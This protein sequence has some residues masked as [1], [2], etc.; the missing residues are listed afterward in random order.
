MSNEIMKG[1][2]P[3]GAMFSH[4]SPPA[5]RQGFLR[6]QFEAEAPLAQLIFDVTVG[7]I[8]PIVCLVFDPVV[9]RGG[10]GSAPELGGYRV[11]A[12]GLIAIEIVVLGVWLATGKR[13]GEWCGVLS[14]VMFAGALFSA[15]VGIVLLPLSILGLALGIGVL[16][17]TPFCAAF[18][19]GRNA[20]RALRAARARMSRAALCLTFAFGLLAAYGAPAFAHWR[21][22]L[23]IERSLPDALGNDEARASAGA[24]RLRHLSPFLTGE[25]DLLVRAYSSEA[26]PARKERLARAYREITGGDI[27]TRLSPLSD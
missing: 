2:E 1:G 21:V 12:Y 3:E 22:K 7:M 9:F 20:R 19:Y 10:F 8:L 5:R 14:G 16:G 11:F 13:A 4:L 23:M 25:L 26:N 6:R 17:F 27:E 24:R 15:G 18:I